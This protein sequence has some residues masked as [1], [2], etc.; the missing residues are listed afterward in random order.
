MSKLNLQLDEGRNGFRPREVLRGAA[1]WQLARPRAGIEVRLC[2]LVEVQG[3]AEA[4][5]VQTVRF[6][7]HTLAGNETPK[8]VKRAVGEYAR[9]VGVASAGEKVQN[10]GGGKDARRMARTRQDLARRGS[11]CG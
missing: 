6:D 5:R 4:R 3:V 1:E 10:G 11:P 8:R 7:R 2:W 9:A